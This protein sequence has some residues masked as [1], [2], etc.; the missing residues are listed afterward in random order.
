MRKGSRKPL[1]FTASDEAAVM[2]RANVSR[3]EQIARIRRDSSFEMNLPGRHGSIMEKIR[4]Q[5]IPDLR[6]NF[7]ADDLIIN[8]LGFGNPSPSRRFS[9]AYEPLA[10]YSAFK[11]N[12]IERFR[13]NAFSINRKAVEKADKA[14]KALFFSSTSKGDF[15]DPEYARHM[16]SVIKETH[17]RELEKQANLKLWD[18][19]TQSIVGRKRLTFHEVQ[20]DEIRKRLSFGR[21][22][23]LTAS[24]ARKG[25]LTV[26]LNVYPFLRPDMK[27]VALKN[28]VNGTVKGGYIVLDS[29][30]RDDE[31]RDHRLRLKKSKSTEAAYVYRVV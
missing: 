6:K 3:R 11:A 13:I 23:I 20:L 29:K 27:K 1:Q 9:T 25:H 31:L 5:V 28:M 21:M 8:D 15:L 16:A 26:C 7:K 2:E 24:P 19:T 12:G 14:P 30:L 22:D 4:L 10:L 18:R 17:A